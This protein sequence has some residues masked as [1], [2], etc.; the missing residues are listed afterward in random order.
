M[1]KRNK[2]NTQQKAIPQAG[3]GG[4]GS[5]MPILIASMMSGSKVLEQS[6]C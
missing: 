3:T 6:E 5:R 1:T 2:H 4:S